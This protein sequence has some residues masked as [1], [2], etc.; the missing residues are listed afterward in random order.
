MN[1]WMNLDYIL[2]IN[3][4]LR[5]ELF[6]ISCFIIQRKWENRFFIIWIFL[7]D[8]NGIYFNFL[9][10]VCCDYFVKG[11]VQCVS[12]VIWVLF[13]ESKCIFVVIF[14]FEFVVIGNFGVVVGSKN[15]Y[16]FDIGF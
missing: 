15:G 12:M 13:I 7:M 5:K 2:K 3:S 1:I 6:N 14:Y 11:Y 16:F 9:F 10:I 8:F 4:W